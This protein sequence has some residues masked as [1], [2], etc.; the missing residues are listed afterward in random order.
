MPGRF[1]GDADTCERVEENGLEA[2]M[3]ACVLGRRLGL[4]TIGLVLAIGVRQE[5][6]D[7]A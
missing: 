2:T 6:P 3:T 4:G 5:G 7:T 1:A